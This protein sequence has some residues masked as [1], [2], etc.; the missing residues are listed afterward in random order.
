[1][2]RSG[3]LLVVPTILANPVVPGAQTGRVVLAPVSSLSEGLYN[4]IYPGE[5]LG[6]GHGVRGKVPE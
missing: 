6:C 1:V 5:Q 4:P 2:K 3:K